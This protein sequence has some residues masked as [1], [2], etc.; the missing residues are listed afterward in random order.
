MKTAVKF[1]FVCSLVLS[2]YCPRAEAD[3]ETHAIASAHPLATAAGF[4][5]LAA[6]GNAFD[7]AV[8]VAA[9]LAVVEPYNSGLGGGG[10]FL[11]HR[12][13]DD[14][15]VMLDARETAPG[16][17]SA[18]MYLDRK[19][20]V[21]PGRS[22][23]GPLAAGI[24]GI[25]AALE[26]LALRYGRL[27]LQQT[28]A[29]AIRHARIG[30]V[31]GAR[32]RAL[33]EAYLP[34]LQRYPAAAAI[35]LQQGQMPV[36]DYRLVQTDLAQTLELL[37][38]KGAAGFYSGTMAQHM[39]KSVRTDGGI[40]REQDLQNYRV[41]ERKPV[42]GEYRGMKIVTAAPPSSGGIVLL[43]TFNILGNFDLPPAGRAQRIHL[44]A[45]AMR[46]SYRDRAEHLGDTD[47]VSVPMEK[48]LNPFYAAGLAAGIR[49][50][51]ASSSAALPGAPVISAGDDTTHFSIIDAA[52]NR[53]AATLSINFPFGSGYVV[54][55]TGV[56]LNN[57]MDDFAAAP[58]VPNGYGLIAGADNPNRIEPGKR[59]LSSMTPTFLEKDGRIAV[60]G[61]PGGS[62][63]ISM[64]LLAALNFWDGGTAAQMAKL[65]RFHHQFMP[66]QIVFEGKA[67]S[68]THKKKLKAMGHRLD[69]MQGTY[70]NMQV[71]ILDTARNRL[72]A[73]SDPRG[74][75]LAEVR[76]IQKLKK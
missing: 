34:L 59:M 33:T 43:E 44:L 36:A 74:E 14:F 66:D 49:I 25:P 40:W 51:R 8:A 46:R 27:S 21:I 29:P 54:P 22:R 69:P 57:E 2:V 72:S 26:H 28:L 65:P 62:R 58:G 35:F 32:Q 16:K 4:E 63:I 45:E 3:T 56:L 75:G 68:W 18:D 20:K 64:V 11:L 73:A 76:K 10:F 19:G 70:G 42:T 60:L 41:V 71:V 39:V 38:Q 7:A 24:P 13:A 23:E 12:A 52:G 47:F 55:G 67:F 9:T 37:A 50:D 48:L 15:D 61:T 6:G 17:A 5:I 53:V 31:A 30:F 1:L